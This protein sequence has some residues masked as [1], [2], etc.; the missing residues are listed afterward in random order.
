MTLAVYMIISTFVVF[1][2][3]ALVA[4]AWGFSDGQW[5]NTAATARLVLE[6]DDPYPGEDAGSNQMGA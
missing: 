1:F 3:G 5:K 4:L 2:T 6:I